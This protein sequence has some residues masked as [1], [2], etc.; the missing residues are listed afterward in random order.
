MKA[1]L[2]S[3]KADGSALGLSASE[4]AIKKTYGKRFSIPLDFQFF[5]YPIYPKGLKQDLSVTIELNSANKVMLVSGDA[6][7]TYTISD[8]VLECDIITDNIYAQ[9][10]SNIYNNPNPKYKFEIP[11]TFITHDKHVVL[12]K[13]DST[14]A[15]DVITSAQNLQGILLLFKDSQATTNFHTKTNN[16]TIQQSNQFRFQLVDIR[17]K[18]TV[19]VFYLDI[20]LLKLKSIFIKSIQILT[21]ESF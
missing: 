10:I 17:I 15:I 5:N 9:T 3:T 13:K 2:G 1:R 12:N 7:A 8:I 16:F 19:G 11:Y 6:N 4:T 20:S 14:W 18:F 21:K